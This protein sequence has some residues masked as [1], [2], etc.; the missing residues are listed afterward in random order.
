MVVASISGGD[1]GDWLAGGWATFALGSLV[2]GFEA[3]ARRGPDLFRPG[4]GGLPSQ[5]LGVRA[6]ATATATLKA[7]DF[8]LIAEAYW[9]GAAYT[10]QELAAILAAPAYL[11]Y[12]AAT[13]GLPGSVGAFHG[14]LRLAWTS[15]DWSAAAGAVI[16]LGTGA[17][18]CTAKVE[19]SV[20]GK[21]G[22]GLE[23]SLPA[24]A[25][26]LDDDELGL[27]GKGPAAKVSITAYF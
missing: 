22:L 1:G 19:A 4:P 17:F 15:G 11:P 27:G 21:A 26:L 2:I 12:Y 13:L 24:P 9:N 6:S 25:A 7:G 10:R 16:D 3:A 20:Q 5:D 8:V 14:L 18:V 23:L